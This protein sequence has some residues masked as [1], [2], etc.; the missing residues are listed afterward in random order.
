MHDSQAMIPMMQR[1]S[2]SFD[3]FYDLADAAY[4]AA[5]TRAMSQGLN[6]V[7]LID[8]NPRRGEKQADDAGA[9][10]VTIIPAEA[11]RYQAV[12]HL[13]HPRIQIYMIYMFHTTLKEGFATA[14]I[15]LL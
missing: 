5:G 3:Y 15:L 10:F 11:V 2:A 12:C 6:H 1:A 13:E 7:P 9:K 14:S 8:G 4:D